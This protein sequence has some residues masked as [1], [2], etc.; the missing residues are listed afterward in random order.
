MAEG[1]K[2]I[3]PEIAQA[4]TPVAPADGA[5][6]TNIVSASAKP[7]INETERLTA[8]LPGSERGLCRQF[9]ARG[10]IWSYPEELR[11]TVAGPGSVTA[12]AE[13]AREGREVAE[14]LGP[15]EDRADPP[16]GGGPGQGGGGD[17]AGLD[18][19]D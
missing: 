15:D 4:P 17:P 16:V 11:A 14:A 3:V 5:G 7:A 12:V 13:E 19:Q 10:A 18:A 6:T 1:V 9:Y 8:V 2:L